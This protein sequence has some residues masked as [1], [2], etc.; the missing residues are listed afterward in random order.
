M[1][2]ALVGGAFLSASLQVMF[3]RL[4]T[5]EFINF[6]SKQKMD[7][8]LLAKLKITL[9]ALQA[10]LDDAEDK[11][12]TNQHVKAWLDELQH[13][14]YQ[15][16]DLLDEIA[17]KALRNKLKADHDQPQTQNNRIKVGLTRFFY[18]IKQFLLQINC[19]VSTPAY[20][21]DEAIESRM[22]E[23]I[24]KLE[25]FVV[26]K[27]ALN[28]R[29]NIG[30]KHS[31][32][33]QTTSLIDESDVY[34]RDYDKEKI[35]ELLLSD[36][37]IRNQIHVIP[38]VGM[39]GVGKTTIAQFVYNDPRVD[40][41]FDMKAWVC[42]SDEFD[43][44]LTTKRIVKAVS[45][46]ADVDNDLNQLQ[47][48]LKQNLAGK[49]FLLVLDDVWIENALDW[50]NLNKPFKAGAQESR[51]I[52]TTRSNNV[53]RV[54]GTIHSHHLDQLPFEDCWSLFA[55]LA[56]VNEDYMAHPELVRIGREIVK[57]C[58][59]LP[60]AIKSIGGI[61]RSKLDIDEWEYL[62]KSEIWGLKES[63]IL[64]ALRLSYHYL[65]SHLKRC[66]AYCS[67]FPKDYNF[68]KE[69]LIRIW[70]A[71]DLV[72]Q[73]K[74]NMLL[75]DAGKD[76]FRELLSRSFFQKLSHDT[77][78]DFVM[79]DL[80][81]DLAQQISGEFCFMLE[82]DKP[83]NQISE[84]VCHFSYV[85]GR[86][87]AFE[88]LKV[89]NEV[90]YLR[91]FIS[92]LNNKWF[93]NPFLGKKVLNDMLPSLRSLRVLSLSEYWISEL[94]QSIGNLIHLRYLDLSWTAL[95]QLPD[96]VT[97][98]CN[99]QTLD[100]SYCRHLTELPVNMGKLINL[101]YLDIRETRLT[102]MP[103]QMSRLK[104]LQHLTYFVVGKDGGSRISE[105]KELCQLRGKLRIS[106]LENVISGPNASEANLK[107]KEHIDMLELEWGGHT[108][109]SQKEREVLD[110]LQPHARVKDLSIINYWGRSFPEW[111][112]RV[113][114]FRNMVSLKLIRCANCY[115]LPSIGQLPSLKHLR[116]K[117]MTEITQVGLE[118]Y[119]DASSSM[120]PFQSLET[121]CFDVM[122][123]W[124]E[125]HALGAGEFSCLL[126]LSLVCCPKLT[127]E[128][129]NHLPCLRKL[130]ISGCEQLL[131]NQ[132][133]LLL[134]GLP[135]LQNLKISG[136]P[137]LKE[138][139][140]E[141]CRLLNLESLEIERC[142]YLETAIE[143][144]LPSTLKAL[145]IE[146]CE[147]LKS[148]T[149]ATSSSEGMNIN[150]NTKRINNFCL[151]ELRISDCSSLLQLSFPFGGLLP[152]AL[153]T[154]DVCNC[155]SLGFPFLSEDLNYH[156]C[157]IEFLNIS[158]CDLLKSLSLSFFPKL[159]SLKIRE[160][161]NIETISIPDDKLQNLMELQ[162]HSCPKMVSF[163]GGGGGLPAPNLTLFRV[164]DCE[165]LKS[166]PQRMHT[167]LPSL[168]DLYIDDCPEVESFP[169]GGL[170]SNLTRLS[171]KNCEK[172]VKGRIGW[173]LQTLPSFRL[174]RI[175]GEYE[176]EVLE[177]FPEEWLLPTTLTNLYIR[178]LPNLK[179][180]NHKGLQ[181]LTSLRNLEI[182][183][184]PKLQSLPE[185]GLPNSLIRLS[186]DYCPLLKP[187]WS[188]ISQIPHVV[189]NDKYY[190]NLK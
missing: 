54:M 98:M 130:T 101:R 66:F 164:S 138:L 189:L 136:M 115:F 114:S 172:L 157:S 83:L 59:G 34:G 142:R 52:I 84:K 167:L 19:F 8:G 177:T 41:N 100:L 71:V 99:L 188:K 77:N 28:L 135:S 159:R 169:N 1:A 162:I 102:E 124:E 25:L 92:L 120:K 112:E 4:A 26:Q 67:I 20:L 122:P 147:A 68:D 103:R 116:I 145:K 17:T 151:E 85:Q 63:N 55:K 174:F 163:A 46:S 104:D 158:G 128:L 51:I 49:K 137:N 118:F 181:H 10:V 149:V 78:S 127:G 9:L 178:Y 165:N 117:A 143:M 2:E 190:L 18:I 132:V 134:Q 111:L 185:E 7:D 16:D 44:S 94:P 156:T 131:P 97:T 35:I 171:I 29:E 14:V 95:I 38:I 61:L 176:E 148:L 47:M 76:Y 182:Y 180:L 152:P 110:Q 39:G 108:N 113:H 75:E 31:Q 12:I 82:D 73:P 27:S 45:T 166:L 139:P 155:N 179:S 153:K 6:F 146:G 15:A 56:F 69:K 107:G 91:T 48:M 81:H 109:D 141:L 96:L 106:G 23:V 105:L 150:T 119:G 125:W 57:K 53:A 168:E 183:D 13:L 87:D 30:R 88:K 11:Q 21:S 160:C 5:R 89:V 186:I 58:R 123:K 140:P 50:E 40:Q 64:P 133:A 60:L 72:Q 36:N 24:S 22:K 121:L 126:E 43:V 65:P 129:P 173:G 37:T 86:Y 3:D 161:K 184:C 187:R 90:K 70:I 32:R 80:I 93:V 42:V 154:L 144:G 74:N 170:P 33:Q 62:L 79:H 175:H